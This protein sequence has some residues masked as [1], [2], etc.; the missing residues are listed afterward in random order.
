MRSVE[1][2]EHLPCSPRRRKSAIMPLPAGGVLLCG[3]I[4]SFLRANDLDVSGTYVLAL[5]LGTTQEI[6]VGRL[7]RIEFPAGWYLYVGSARGPGGLPARLARHRRRLGSDKRAHWHLDYLREQTTWGGAW[8]RASGERLECTWAAR[9]RDLP[10]AAIVTP[11]FG[12]SDCRCPAHL[13]RVATLPGDEWFAGTLG[14][15]RSSVGRGELDELLHILTSGSEDAREAAALALGRFGSLAIGPL[16]EMLA[17]G[18]AD[19]R[20]WAT[21]A[22]VEVGGDGATEPLLGALTDPDPDVRACAALALGRLGDRAAAPALVVRL[23]DESAFVA[24]IA[25]DG[26]AM[27]GEPAV[28]SLAEALAHEDAHVRLL[29]VRALSRIRAQSTIG[30]L[31]GA[32]EDPSYL[33]RYYA[34]EALEALGVGMVFVAP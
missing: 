13:V 10:A 27:I 2:L 1:G 4:G 24:G 15:E 23:T 14:A 7:G 32:L 25:G 29:A 19:A 5:W 11:G 16:T 21:R 12:A 28:E 33:V 30:P 22:L 17:T 34:Q 26:L 8:V 3:R 20:W 9:L 18:D 6:S 31:F